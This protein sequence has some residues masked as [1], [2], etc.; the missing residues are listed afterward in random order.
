MLHQLLKLVMLLFQDKQRSNRMRYY[1]N[2][3]VD[4]STKLQVLKEQVSEWAT[5]RDTMEQMKKE[6]YIRT[7]LQGL[8][9]DF[10]RRPAALHILEETALLLA[11]GVAAKKKIVKLLDQL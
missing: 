10:E 7:I 1:R 4:L 3:R 11:E 6:Q 9:S 5:C 8:K 2:I